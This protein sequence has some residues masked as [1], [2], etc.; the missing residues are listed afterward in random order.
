MKKET[1]FEIIGVEIKHSIDYEGQPDYI[2]KFTDT[3]QS[4]AIVRSQRA[5]NEYPM[6]YF[7]S[8]NNVWSKW[9]QDWEGTREKD[10]QE[11]I[12]KYGSLKA[13]MFQ[14]AK[15]DMKRLESLGR[16]WNYI[17]VSCHAMIRITVGEHVFNDQCYDSLY[18]VESD[19]PE[20]IKEVEKDLITNVQFELLD[21]G[22][23]LIETEQAFREIRRVEDYS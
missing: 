13:A 7:V 12:A 9:R 20:G 18:G 14:W 10:R 2:G 15:E 11:I 23:T 19:S 17:G 16:T 5:R 3:W 6:K 21:I 4:G 1:D 22:F 8:A